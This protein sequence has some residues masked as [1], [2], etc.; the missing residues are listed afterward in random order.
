MQADERNQN[1]LIF[2]RSRIVFSQDVGG[3]MA[4]QGEA[5]SGNRN[6]TPPP[7]LPVRIALTIDLRQSTVVGRLLR[8]LQN[9]DLDRVKNVCPQAFSGWPVFWRLTS[10]RSLRWT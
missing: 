10:G 9:P 8:K 6:I 4:A 7:A 5:R 3:P 1:Y 2:S